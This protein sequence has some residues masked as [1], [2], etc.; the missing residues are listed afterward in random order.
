MVERDLY[1]SEIM[2][3]AIITIIIVLLVGVSNVKASS[4]PWGGTG[5]YTFGDEDPFFAHGEIYDTASLDIVGGSFGSLHCFDYSTVEM[6]DGIGDYI[7][8]RESS[9]INLYGG[10]LDSLGGF[11][12]AD[13]TMFVESYTIELDPFIGYEARLTGNWFYDPGTFDILIYDG[14]LSHVAVEIVPEPS[15]LVIFGIGA[16]MILKNR[17]T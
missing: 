5:T 11:D 12:N 8:G 3:T 17:K 1:R 7:Y 10:T 2:K 6:F 13:I 16:L 4:P 9:K 14:S 15:T